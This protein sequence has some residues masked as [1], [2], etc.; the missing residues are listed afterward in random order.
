MVCTTEV[1]ECRLEQAIC[2]LQQLSN[3]L[4][5]NDQGS[6]DTPSTVEELQ[7]WWQ[8]EHRIAEQLQRLMPTQTAD[9]IR[10]MWRVIR[11]DD[12]E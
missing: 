9:A 10:P 6:R 5:L 8:C 2:R 4:D 7:E 12:C 11:G 3:R 1:D